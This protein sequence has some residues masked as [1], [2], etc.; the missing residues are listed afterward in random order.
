MPIEQWPNA[1]TNFDSEHPAARFAADCALQLEVCQS[2][3]SLADPLPG[4]ISQ[5]A[6]EHLLKGLPATLAAHVSFQSEAAFPLLKRRYEENGNLLRCFRRLEHQHI[7]IAGA[8]DELME[9]LTAALNGETVDVEMLGYLIRNAC[10]LRREHVEWEQALL[11]WLF[12]SVLAPIERQAF[13]AWS[14]ENPLP[15]GGMTR[16]GGNA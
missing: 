8:D 4:N 15:F 6:V 7:K 3:V 2:P 9:R 13:V 5:I 11:S 16:A 10:E 1:E 14:A 12:P